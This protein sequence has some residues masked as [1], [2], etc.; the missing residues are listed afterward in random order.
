MELVYG[1]EPLDAG[2]KATANP[3]RVMSRPWGRIT[4]LGLVD[5]ISQ[6]L[7]YQFSDY[8]LANREKQ[9]C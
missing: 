8:T 7:A 6:A 4:D 5:S 2:Q 1:F 3:L 9:F